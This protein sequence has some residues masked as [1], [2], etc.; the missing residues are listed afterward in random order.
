MKCLRA[1]DQR[2]TSD[3]INSDI[4]DCANQELIRY[5]GHADSDTRCFQPQN[6]AYIILNTCLKMIIRALLFFLYINLLSG[7]STSNTIPIPEISE[8][9]LPP[10]GGIPTIISKPPGPGPFP[11]VVLL[12]GCG[13]I[14]R[15]SLDVLTGYAKHFNS[16]GYVTAIPDSFSPRTQRDV[17]AD[18]SIVSALDRTEDA[19]SVLRYL[20][21]AGYVIPSEVAVLGQ[22][23]GAG[24]VLTIAE[25]PQYRL[26]E[27]FAGGIALYP[28]CP[29]G[30]NPTRIPLLVLIGGRDSWTP[31]PR[32]DLYTERLKKAGRSI[33][34]HVYQEAAHSYD[35]PGNSRIEHGH[36]LGWD[37]EA[38]LDTAERIDLFL[39]AVFLQKQ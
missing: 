33:E 17:C 26:G 21:G 32:C 12:H 2:A 25:K 6:T 34:Y 19:F 38:A 36:L 23:H 5:N 1:R 20:I 3:V 8:S 35:M 15:Y 14:N 9:V 18:T 11:A 27:E 4:S 10:A 31:A 16:L 13:G 7:C 29:D 28:R 22:S 30:P 37:G 39:R 24:T